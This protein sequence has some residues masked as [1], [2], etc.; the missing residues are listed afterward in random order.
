VTL[1]IAASRPG[2]QAPA[3]G[4]IKDLAA[5]QPPPAAALARWYTATG[6]G[7]VAG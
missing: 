5:R 2:D 1:A 6:P 3:Q 7:S 4:I